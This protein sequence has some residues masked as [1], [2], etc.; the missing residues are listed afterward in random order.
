M[1]DKEPGVGI[2]NLMGNIEKGVNSFASE[3]KFYLVLAVILI[4]VGGIIYRKLKR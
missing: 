1:N 3:L 4:I 2:E